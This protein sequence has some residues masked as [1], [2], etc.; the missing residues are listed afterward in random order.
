MNRNLIIK[1]AAELVTVS[2]YAAKKGKEMSSLNVIHN[3]SL[4]IENGII[5]R[6]GKT[7]D[8]LD[9]LETSR[10][11]VIDAKGK[12]VLPGF[13]DPHTHF[14]FAGYRAYE[15]S[16]RL[17]GIS[18]MEIMKRGGGIKN[19]VSETR[20]A[21]LDELINLGKHRLDSMLSM[22]VTTIE[23]KSGYGLDYDTEIRQLKAMSILNNT[24]PVDI[25]STFMGAHA[26]PEEF[27]DNPDGFIDYLIAHVLPDVVKSGLAE[28]CD[29]FCEEGVFTV[30]QS[31]CLLESAQ[32]LGLKAKVHADELTSSGGSRLAVELM[33]I[34]ADHL[35]YISDDD[36][37]RI[38]RSNVVA[39]LLPLT[40]FCLKEPY[41]R[42]RYMIDK[43]CAIALATDFNPGSCF[44]ESIP[45]VFALATIYMGMTPEE[46]VCAMTLNAASAIDRAKTL[47]SLDIGKIGDAVILE[48]PS[49]IYIPYHTGVNSVEKVIKKGK[50]VVDKLLNKE[51][52]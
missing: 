47:G 29:V 43:G 15:F 45:L 44:S 23:G 52:L 7:D 46:T 13:I 10:F 32:A 38:A 41:A 5:T 31:R 34:S 24:H 14:I 21:T 3:G 37:D 8:V 16:W 6:I 1:D 18:Y 19:S 36:I 42:A 22:G 4:V 49:Y 33:A 26:I 17:S 35:L 20:K 28:F 50:I 48:F 2:G 12:S 9:G 51:N 30:K 40:A 39:T 25:V 27:K 11:V